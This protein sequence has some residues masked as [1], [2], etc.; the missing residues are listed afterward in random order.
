MLAWA[1]KLKIFMD[2][3]M[4]CQN[5]VKVFGGVA[6]DYII[7][8]DIIM[9]LCTPTSPLEGRATVHCREFMTYG[10]CHMLEYSQI[11]NSNGTSVSVEEIGI[12]HLRCLYGLVPTKARWRDQRNHNKWIN[13]VDGCLSDYRKDT[14]D[15][16]V[17]LGNVRK[18]TT[19]RRQVVQIPFPKRWWDTVDL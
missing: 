4:F 9:G 6:P 12:E 17:R 8:H 14:I 5:S 10:L 2:I 11:S 13:G 18:E 19:P 1:L 3:L 16:D 15:T 7:I